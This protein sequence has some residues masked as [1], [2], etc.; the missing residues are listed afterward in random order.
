MNRFTFGV[1]IIVLVLLVGCVPG[2]ESTPQESVLTP[3]PSSA[4]RP[5]VIISEV[6][7]DQTTISTMFRD[8]SYGLITDIGGGIHI[9]ED[10]GATWTYIQDAAL[11][12]VALE[13]VDENL[14]WHI[15][16]IG[17]VMRSTDAGRSWEYRTTLPYGG[18][19]EYVSSVD[20]Q[21]VWAA[22]TEIQTYWVSTDGAATWTGHPL[23]EGMGTVA[24]LH[25]RTTQDAYFLDLAGN[26]FITNDSGASWQKHTLGLPEGWL[27]PELNHSAAMRFTD[28][29]HGLVALNILGEGSGKVFALRMAG[30]GETWVEEE[31]PVPMGMFHLTRD[32]IYLTH[33]DLIDQS[34]ITLLTQR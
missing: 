11:S 15:G 5:W 32:G 1:G 24:A 8:A 13:M 33:V 6:D 19:I 21:T 34:L 12:R 10:G 4:Q 29:D 26:L 25:L 18:H 3:E 28:A 9:T 22:S 16:V 17:P 2:A 27:I 30:G 14:F 23:P 20:A 7:F 31:L